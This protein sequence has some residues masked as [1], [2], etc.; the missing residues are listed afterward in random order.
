MTDAQVDALQVGDEVH[1]HPPDGVRLQA[2][3]EVRADGHVE[4][5]PCAVYQ[6]ILAGAAVILQD[7]EMHQVGL[8]AVPE[9]LR[10]RFHAP[11]DCPLLVGDADPG[12]AVTAAGTDVD[13]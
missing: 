8:H 6:V 7:A 13:R 4:A 1:L 12:D 10:E 9:W 11:A 3:A 2:D 5:G